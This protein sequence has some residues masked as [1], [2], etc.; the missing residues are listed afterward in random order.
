MS[1]SRR[2][3]HAVTLPGGPSFGEVR[4]DWAAGGPLAPAFR[5]ALRA[6]PHA[7]FFWETPGVPEAA[8]CRTPFE[9][10]AIDAPALLVP[11]DPGAFAEH[12]GDAPA[13]TFENLGGG[14][15]LIAPAP[16]PGLAAAY[17]AEFVRTASDDQWLAVLR[18][19][20]A[21]DRRDR[22]RGRRWLSTSGTGVAWLHVRLDP[23]PKYY[24]HRPYRDAG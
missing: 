11:A 8:L 4:D 9:G 6:V 13:A 21:A 12:F 15:T 7:A 20:A 5:R 19:V 1:S 24:Q 18:A 3:P 17:L 22:P 14:S 23:R 10:V 2:P 16:R